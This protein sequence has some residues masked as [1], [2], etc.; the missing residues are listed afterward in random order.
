MDNPNP[1]QLK[2]ERQ[3]AL[4]RVGLLC[5]DS[6]YALEVF[7]LLLKEARRAGV[8]VIRVEEGEEAG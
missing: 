2:L 1:C 7:E 6:G 3:G 8:R 4:V 5:P